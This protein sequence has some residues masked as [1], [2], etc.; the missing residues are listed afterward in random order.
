[1]TLIL[2]WQ[3]N[4][5]QTRKLET[6]MQKNIVSNSAYCD[7]DCNYSELNVTSDSLYRHGINEGLLCYLSWNWFSVAS[8]TWR[9]NCFSSS[10]LVRSLLKSSTHFTLH[11]AVSLT[12]RSSFTR[13][14][15][16]LYL[17]CCFM[18]LRRYINWPNYI[19]LHTSTNWVVA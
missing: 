8:T 2:V 18:S 16:C 17:L 14:L 11:S 15:P 19:T 3:N 5:L 12:T 10:S 9:R 6:S 1:M 7:V 4:I 13:S